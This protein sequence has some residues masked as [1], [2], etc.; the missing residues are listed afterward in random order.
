MRRVRRREPF[1]PHDNAETLEAPLRPSV[2]RA[3]VVGFDAARG[4]AAYDGRMA[5]GLTYERK[6][7]SIEATK[8]LGQTLS[9]Y[10][11]EGDVIVLSGDL[12]AGKTQFVQGVAA[13]LGITDDVVSPTFNIVLEYTQ[14][15]LPL[16]HFDLYRLEDASELEDV[17]YYDLVE[18]DGVAFLEWGERFP[19]A[20]P[21]GY[22]DVSIRVDAAGCRLIRVQSVGDRA[23]QLLCVWANDS[24]SHLVKSSRK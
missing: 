16:Y 24:R 21:Y 11:H 5:N 10:L 17:G 9:R 15:A 22:L 1:A 14:G 13:G 20:L 2:F 7:T 19:E 18:G 3:D 6:T 12:G 23:R 4:D 8:Q